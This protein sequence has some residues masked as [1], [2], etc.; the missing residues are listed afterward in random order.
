MENPILVQL[1]NIFGHTNNNSTVSLCKVCYDSIIAG[2]IPKY[3]ALNNMYLDN[4]PD[5]IA[6]LNFY[7]KLLIQKAK[8]F[9]TVIKLNNYGGNINKMPAIKGLA[10]Y[11]PLQQNSTQDYVMKT[12]P[13]AEKLNFIVEG[14]P[15]KS[16]AIFRGLVD[17]EK[18]FSALEW[19]KS[20]NP[21][22]NDIIIDKDLLNI[23]GNDSDPNSIPLNDSYLVRIF[24]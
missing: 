23:F 7:E 5:E 17:L 24:F 8:C 14:L 20:N 12:L 22:Y 3:S 1:F 6:L 19:L 4:V 2:N 16:N 15:T 9:M 21:L 10:V 18:V 13:N 11:L